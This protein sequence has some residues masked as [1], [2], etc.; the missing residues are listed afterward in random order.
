MNPLDN[1][2]DIQQPAEIGLW[3]PAYGWWM[4]AILVLIAIVLSVKFI[5]SYAQKRKAQKQAL[6]ALD[7]I[8][9]QDTMAA[10]Q[11]NQ[12][13]KRVAIAYFPSI[14]VQQ[15]H[16]Q[17]W[18][19]FL[20]QALPES[21]AQQQQAT[22]EQMQNQLYQ[23]TGQ[24]NLAIESIKQSAQLWIKKATPPNTKTLEKLEHNYA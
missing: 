10:N 12:L 6:V 11:I 14:N 17:H 1:L 21:I 20:L 3:P 16:G 8:N 7:Q 18:V 23:A 9:V 15:L 5:L 22:L 24:K 13:L 2:K 4:L 19:D